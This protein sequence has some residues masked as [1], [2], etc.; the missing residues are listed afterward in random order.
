MNRVPT[1]LIADDEMIVARTLARAFHRVGISSLIETH[2]R[3]V[4]D[5]AEAAQPEFIVLDIRQEVDGRDVLAALK[6]N[7]RTARIPVYML[8]SCD[9]Q[10]VRRTCLELGAEDYD[11]KPFDC[12]YV[13]HVLRRLRAHG[14]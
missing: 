8:S 10:F 7:P 12:L 3:E 5:R 4:V 1:V 2:A 13:E 9:D 14:H 6:R 11:T